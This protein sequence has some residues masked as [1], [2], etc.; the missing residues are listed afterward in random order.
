MIR[1]RIRQVNCHKLCKS[2]FNR[3]KTCESNLKCLGLSNTYSSNNI[4]IVDDKYIEI[5][6]LICPRIYLVKNADRIRTNDHIV[7]QEYIDKVVL[8]I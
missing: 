3:V 6:L 2:Y 4:N 7:V 5:Y 8:I 1:S